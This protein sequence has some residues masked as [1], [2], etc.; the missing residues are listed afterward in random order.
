MIS[1]E[2]LP[3]KPWVPQ[4]TEA[5]AEVLDVA[6]VGAALVSVSWDRVLLSV[7][8]AAVFFSVQITGSPIAMAS[9]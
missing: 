6:I 3:A 4:R 9:M 7:L 8:A 1:S 5:G 2:E